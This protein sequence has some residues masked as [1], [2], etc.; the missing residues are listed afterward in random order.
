MTDTPRERMRDVVAERRIVKVGRLPHAVE[1]LDPEDYDALA[2]A[3]SAALAKQL[4]TEHA[5]LHATLGVLAE[6][7]AANVE[8]SARVAQLE[9][10]IL[11]LGGTWAA[12]PATPP[13]TG[14][15]TVAQG[16][17]L[18]PMAEIDVRLAKLLHGTPAAPAGVAPTCPSRSP[19][20]GHAC[21]ASPRHAGWHRAGLC[22]DSHRAHGSDR[23]WWSA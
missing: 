23:V 20:T 5:A 14:V 8:L 11:D 6:T 13:D 9:A 3:A 12:D 17:T 10:G 15:P 21:D 7:R 16:I 19:I 1:T 18:D 22:D 4:E 2:E